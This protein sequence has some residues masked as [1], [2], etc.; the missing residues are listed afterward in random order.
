MYSFVVWAAFA[1]LQTDMTDLT[2]DLEG[3]GM[4]F[5]C[6]RDYA[7]NMLFVALETKP[8]TSDPENPE[9]HVERAM[10]KFSDLLGNKTFLLTIIQILDAESKSKLPVRE[11][12]A[13]ASLLTVVMMAENKLG[14]LTDILFSMMTQLVQDSLDNNHPRRL[15]RRTETIVEK[16][17]SNWI[18]LCLY[19]SVKDYT[20]YPL[21]LLYRAIKCHCENGPMDVISG[22]A[23]FTLSDEKLLTEDVEFREMTLTVVVNDADGETKEVKVLDVDSISQVKEK[24][25]D[26]IYRNKPYSTRPSA[27]E[28]DLGKNLE[29][30]FYGATQPL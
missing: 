27:K 20:G 24:I 28:V 9:E 14:Y 10:K 8:M 13:I 23:K 26:A 7:T 2:S 17:L 21:F 30:Y 1:E 3:L 11:K 5:V 4:P 18:A 6:Q 19:D 29:R 12:A 22:Q 15:F 25:L 16:L